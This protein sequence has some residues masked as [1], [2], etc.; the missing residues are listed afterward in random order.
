M[1]PRA[2]FELEGMAGGWCCWCCW[3]CWCELAAAWDDE[4]DDDEFLGR[5]AWGG[6]G[7][8]RVFM[9]AGGQ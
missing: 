6:V 2:A 5:A 7:E 8:G 9:A 3:C 1:V 4:M